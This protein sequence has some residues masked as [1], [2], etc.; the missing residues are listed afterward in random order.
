MKK[1][2]TVTTAWE[3]LRIS[4]DFIF[5]KIMQD[6][7]LCKELLQRILP[8]LKIDHIE[9]PEA[10]KVI[11]PDIDAK[12]VRL[13]VYVVDGKGTVYDIEMQ[14]AISPELPKRTRYYQSLLDT[15]QQHLLFRRE[16]NF[17]KQLWFKGSFKHQSFFA[18]TP[19]LRL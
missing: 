12:S 3:E 17:Y 7:H 18:D 14:V 8:D 10:Q 6:S 4:N 11:R 19:I 5:G 2:V 1:H 15:G 9:Y 13:D 16:Q